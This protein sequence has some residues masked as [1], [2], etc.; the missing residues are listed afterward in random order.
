MKVLHYIY[1]LNIGGAESFLLNFLSSVHTVDCTFDFCIQ[2]NTIKNKDLEKAIIRQ[3]GHIHFIAPYNKRPLKNKN[4][5]KRL[6]QECHYD[7]V[8]FHL[9]SLLNLFPIVICV[10]EGIKV[11]V[12]SHNSK[13]NGGLLGNALHRIN[14]NRIRKLDIGRLSCGVE[15]GEWFFGDE[16]YC[17]IN[18]GIISEKF[19]YNNHIRKIIREL[20]KIPSECTVIG[21]VGRF[22]EQKNHKFIVD[23]FYEYHIN[24]KNSFL[25]LIGDG[26]RKDDIL[27]RVKKKGLD[28]S[29]IFCGN[30]DNAN[31]CLASMDVMLFPSLYEGLPFTLIEAQAA[32]VPILA[33]DVISKNV[34]ITNLITFK[35]LNDS[36]E[37]WSTAL[38]N[39]IIK[40]EEQ[41]R[42]QYS[43]TVKD[44][45]YDSEQ[46]AIKLMKYYR[47][48]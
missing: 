42:V 29:V 21:H 17:I 9:N 7:V 20:Y 44:T 27:E 46:T 32:G 37:S 26:E 4:D 34:S 22:S 10:K 19:K 38:M 12:H 48:L 13:S 3:H 6:V 39:S 28:K 8:H 14:K 11:I 1:G 18:N 15:A 30:V 24:N 43:E 45:E 33:S 47:E 25:M 16:K 2:S 40:S 35:S 36:P 41:E 23:V 31:E 5:F